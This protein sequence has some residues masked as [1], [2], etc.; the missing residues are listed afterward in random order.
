MIWEGRELLVEIFLS[1][2]GRNGNVLD[3]GNSSET[4]EGSERWCKHSLLDTP[5]RMVTLVMM[6]L[7]V[8]PAAQIHSHSLRP[9]KMS[10]ALKL[11]DTTKIVR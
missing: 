6:S 11:E 8:G 3:C 10:G 7:T 5:P 4:K 1:D 2:A 9:R